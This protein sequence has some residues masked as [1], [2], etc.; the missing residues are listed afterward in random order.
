MEEE[1]GKKGKLSCGAGT[2]VVGTFNLT[3]T[4]EDVFRFAQCSKLTGSVLSFNGKS[5]GQGESEGS[6]RKQE[7]A[8]GS[9]RKQERR[10][11]R[12]TKKKEEER[13]EKGKRR[14]EKEKEENKMKK[15]KE[16]GQ[17]D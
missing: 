16:K 13:R 17:E 8:R 1:K 5:F 3:H 14:E 12:R 4:V 9:K 15:R 11:R 7:E 10:R 2:R 6:K